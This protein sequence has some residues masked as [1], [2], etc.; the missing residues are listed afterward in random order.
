[1][2]MNDVLSSVKTR[3]AAVSKVPA[4]EHSV[5][6]HC[7]NLEALTKTLRS[8]GMEDQEINRNVLAVF[9]EY[10][11]GLLHTVSQMMKGAA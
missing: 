9:E 2:N 10:E 3:L 5:K 11:R 6:R 8:I 1:M 7:E 4:L